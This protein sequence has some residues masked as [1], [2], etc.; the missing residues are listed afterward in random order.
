MRRRLT[1]DRGRSK[2]FFFTTRRS[3]GRISQYCRA[4]TDF[5]F[6]SCASFAAA[7]GRPS[8]VS[9]PFSS[10]QESM[11]R[12]STILLFVTKSLL[13]A[14]PPNPAKV[15]LGRNLRQ[16]DEI[17]ASHPVVALKIASPDSVIRPPASEYTLPKPS[18]SPARTI[19]YAL[20]PDSISRHQQQRWDRRIKRVDEPCPVGQLIQESNQGV[21]GDI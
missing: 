3:R 18:R 6:L 14:C 11:S 9:S 17:F 12:T 8:G 15:I 1:Q 20:P 7:V 2:L 13:D 10:L 4:P 21:L 5:S 19:G 16:G